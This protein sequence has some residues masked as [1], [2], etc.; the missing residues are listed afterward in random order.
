MQYRAKVLI[1]RTGKKVEFT[2][3]GKLI[4]F[5]PGE[6]RPV[7]GFEAYHA[8]NMVN[9][10]LEEFTPE[11]EAEEAEKATRIMPDYASMPWPKLLKRAKKRFKPGMVKEDVVRLLQEHWQKKYDDKENK[12]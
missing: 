7:E 3:G 4:I 1:N 2:C 5:K 10:G 6:T 8:L 9:C 12:K 11:V